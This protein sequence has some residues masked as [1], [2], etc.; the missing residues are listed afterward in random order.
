MRQDSVITPNDFSGSDT[1]RINAAIYA[2]A[3]TGRRVVIPRYN[4]TPGGERDI[5]VLDSAILVLGDTTLEL[6]NCHIK[7]ADHC[8]DNMI[9][10]ANCGIDVTD[11]Q[12]MQR[13]HIHGVGRVVLEGA[14]R[15]RATGDGGKT[16]GER[17]FGTDAGIEGE[18]QKGDWRNIGIL[19]ARVEDFSITNLH[20]KDTHCWAI[21][22]ERCA[23]GIMR[24][25]DFA[26]TSK[27]MIDG[28]QQTI[29]N[30][31]G[32][33]LRLGCHDI[34]IENITGFTG[35]DLIALTG[36][37]RADSTPGALATT[38]VG[39]SRDRG[40]GADD[41]RHVIIKNVRGHSPGGC[42]IVRL[43][44]S[45]GIRMYDILIDGLVD[46]SP[47]GVQ[48]RA[49]V[50]IGDSAYG[51]GVAPVGDTRR[52]VVNNVISKAQHVI[53]LGGSLCDSII[54]NIICHGPDSEAVTFTAGEENTRDVTF[55]NV[56]TCA[57]IQG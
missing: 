56:I 28:V 5:W 38:M 41:I 20:M 48:S 23:H 55:T 18:S 37:G 36:I 7:L 14:D 29:L 16:L 32:I 11:I 50:K 49:A 8:R 39:G 42:H 35:D 13:I 31:D 40:D 46:T 33:D 34:L 54:S 19:L 21:S 24:D 15:P 10:S 57:D 43:L 2:A 4:Q 9:R 12:P 47:A 17:T 53:Q 26:S 44:N 1:E 6:D 45:S 27:K 25:L 22:L 52:I 51:S 30:Q 3:G